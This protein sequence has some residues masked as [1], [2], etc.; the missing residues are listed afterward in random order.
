MSPTL[1]AGICVLIVSRT[2]AFN[3]RN[4]ILS[5]FLA[6]RRIFETFDMVKVTLAPLGGLL[7]ILKLG[8]APAR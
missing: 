8:L 4:V 1:E 3:Q 5:G 7:V 2:G 6:R